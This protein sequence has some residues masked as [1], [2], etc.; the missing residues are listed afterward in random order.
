MSYLEFPLEIPFITGSTINGAKMTIVNCS[1]IS[2]T[3]RMGTEE[4]YG[5][6]ADFC[7]MV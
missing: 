1:R 4:V 5:Y 7:L 3:S 6:S 2:T